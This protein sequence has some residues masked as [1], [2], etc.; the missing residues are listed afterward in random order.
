MMKR[1]TILFFLL[2]TELFSASNNI[3]HDDIYTKNIVGIWSTNFESEDRRLY[4]ETL[5]KNDGTSEGKGEI[6]QNNQ[7]ENIHFTA[8]WYIRNNILVST[9]ITSNMKD[10]LSIGSQQKDRIIS[11]NS[12]K[13]TLHSESGR[14][15]VKN[16]VLE[17]KF[18]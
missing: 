11:L 16:K 5:F 3:Y 4:A 7:C 2:F 17:S 9:I 1:S 15:L 14:K 10:R 8:K 18:F 6:C 13:L 12:I